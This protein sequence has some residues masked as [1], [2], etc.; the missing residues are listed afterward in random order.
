MKKEKFYPPTFA[1]EKFHCPHCGVFAK[2]FWSHLSANKYW[3]DG[4][5]NGVPGFDE[6]LAKDW[7]ISKCEHCSG[8]IIWLDDKVIYPDQ[9]SVDNPNEDL[10]EDIKKDYMEASEIFNKSPRG[11]AAL[12][13]LALT[14]LLKQLGEKGD[15]INDDIIN[16]IKNKGLNPTV[17]KALYFIRVTGNNAVHPGVID[18]NDNKEVAQK[19]FQVI[20][21]IAEKMIT[22][23]NEIDILFN[24]LPK[25]EKDRI[26]NRNN[27]LK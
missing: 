24:D 12:L 27:K 6:A 2:Q 19:L 10:D 23:F 15:S 5:I 3:N 22:D 13:R 4:Y 20:N 18:L 14:K 9:I 21:F 8:Y 16:L 7:R 26:E 25:I 17:Q 11:A 1:E